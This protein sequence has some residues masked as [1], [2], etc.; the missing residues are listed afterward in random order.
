MLGGMLYHAQ[1]EVV[2]HRSQIQIA[3]REAEIRQENEAQRGE[4][5]VPF[6]PLGVRNSFR[7]DNP[8]IRK[9]STSP[10]VRMI[11]TN[12][13]LDY[14]S[15]A[16]KIIAKNIL[17]CAICGANIT[18]AIYAK[19]KLTLPFVGEN[20]F[21]NACIFLMHQQVSGSIDKKH[22]AIFYSVTL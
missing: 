9:D 4:G 8:F 20:I 15:C 5:L 16:I 19:E 1:Q 7:S 6:W 14:A 18:F 12:L 21:V 2:Y 3:Q 11:F 10:E 17:S 22:S 13:N